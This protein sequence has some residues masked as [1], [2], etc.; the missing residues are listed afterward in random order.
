MQLDRHSVAP[1]A[2][3]RV[4]SRLER[5]IAHFIGETFE[6]Q[7]R[8]IPAGYDGAVFER[9]VAQG[10]V[11]GSIGDAIREGRSVARDMVVRKCTA[12]ALSVGPIVMERCTID[13]LKTSRHPAEFRGTAW[14][15][16]RFVGPCGRIR[17]HDSSAL[18]LSA[19]KWFEEIE[20]DNVRRHAEAEFA[21]DIS[22][23]TFVDLDLRA[24]PA[25]A[26]RVNRTDQFV[27][28]RAAL[29]AFVAEP[30]DTARAV[31]TA[32]EV[33]L[34]LFPFDF[35]VVEPRTGKARGTFEQMIE[36]AHARGLLAG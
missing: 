31:L 33:H 36:V 35:V 19:R 17:I 22:E 8:Q 28:D 3:P 9:C 21:I 6:G 24:I 12:N 4:E 16:C 14:V 1:G 25:S 7:L 18:A 32:F 29:Q 5:F 13:S 34:D 27:F 30:G 15:G 23:A 11:I 26:V 10:V 2:E 20:A